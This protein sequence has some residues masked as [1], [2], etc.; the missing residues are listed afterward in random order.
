MKNIIYTL[1][2]L[3]TLIL[4]SC[5]PNAI[6]GNKN[7][8]EN[9]VKISDY[10]NFIYEMQGSSRGKITYEQRL[11]TIPYLRIVT[12]E[13]IFSLL[14]I[15]SDSTSLSIKVEGNK[16]LNPSKLEIYTN[17]PEL[18]KVVI[19]GNVNTLLKGNVRTPELTFELYGAGD[20]VSD[21]LICNSI[22]SKVYGI[23]RVKLIG[24]TGK[25]EC[26]ISGKSSTDTEN[27]LAD[28]VVCIG[29]GMG[30]FRVHAYKYLKAQISGMGTVKYKG[31]PTVD[32]EVSGLGK[33]SKID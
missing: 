8:T 32:K 1:C 29:E 24:K 13:N 2:I 12:D 4:S 28:S 7:I 9:I 26:H 30:S 6:R 25:I 11:D 20:F 19:A 16:K 22:V 33:V 10:K 14:D 18:T 5:D 27:L 3:L 15:K 23:S 17:S 31:N 21:S